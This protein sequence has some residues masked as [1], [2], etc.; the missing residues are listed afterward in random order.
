MINKIRTLFRVLGRGKH[1]QAIQKICTLFRVL[2]WGGGGVRMFNQSTRY[3]H[4]L[5]SW[6]GMGWGGVRMFNQSR[7]YAHSS[8]SWGGAGPGWGKNVQSFN[9][10]RTPFR[11][12]VERSIR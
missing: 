9:K 10:I 1:V 5:G 4:S 6:G 2:G 11:V 7:R 3:A 8:K 12:L